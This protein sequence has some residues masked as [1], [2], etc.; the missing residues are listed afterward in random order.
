MRFQHLRDRTFA[1]SVRIVKFCRTIPATWEGRCIAGQLLRS[2]TSVG[3]NYR[4]ACRAR[5]PAEFIAKLGLVVEESDESEYWLALLEAC[6]IS[7][8]PDRDGLELEAS[9]LRA[10]FVASVNTARTNATVARRKRGN[11]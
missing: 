4:A 3:A 5:S 7:N 6:A 2:G 1:F 8:G 9:E 11:S 10:I